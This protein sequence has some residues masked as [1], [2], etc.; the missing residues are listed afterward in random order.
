MV[1]TI[2]LHGQVN[3]PQAYTCI[4]FSDTMKGLAGVG[5]HALEQLVTVR[6]GHK[7]KEE[8]LHVLH[9]P[10]TPATSAVPGLRSSPKQTLQSLHW[11]RM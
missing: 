3:P 5:I 8:L 1:Q 11:D 7:F 10:Q 2:L 6:D 4:C 9:V